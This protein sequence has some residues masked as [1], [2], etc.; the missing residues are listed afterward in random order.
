MRMEEI[1][2][3][4][5]RAGKKREVGGML[6]VGPK[7]S[8]QGWVALGFDREPSAPVGGHGPCGGGGGGSGTWNRRNGCQKKN[9]A[10]FIIEGGKRAVRSTKSPTDYCL[11]NGGDRKRGGLTIMLIYR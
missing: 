3:D 5:N 9:G 2:F 8:S 7:P 1:S 4:R 11:A 10:I 6:A